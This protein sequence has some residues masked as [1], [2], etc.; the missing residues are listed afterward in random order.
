MKNLDLS[1]EVD[2]SFPEFVCSDIKRIKQVLIN[3]L[4]NAFKFTFSGS[5]IVKA[6]YDKNT[7]MVLV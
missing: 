5:I 2:K 4:N 6:T 7:R 1:L 3:L